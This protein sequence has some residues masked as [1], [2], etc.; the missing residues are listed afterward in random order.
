MLHG[1]NKISV[2]I[3]DTTEKACLTF[4]SYFKPVWTLQHTL[5]KLVQ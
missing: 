3:V 5:R 2:S 4:G 1:I